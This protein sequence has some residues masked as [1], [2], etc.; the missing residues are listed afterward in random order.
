MKNFVVCLAL[1]LA[2]CSSPSG[3]NDSDH[4]GAGATASSGGSSSGGNTGA[5]ASGGT[6][7]GGTAGS[8]P[9]A[10]GS[11]AASGS[12]AAG[13][14]AP[15]PGFDGPVTT[16]RFDIDRSTLPPLYFKD[17]TLIV[18]ALDAT[19]A[20]VLSDGTVVDSTL[21]DGNVMF[22][23][24]GSSIEVQLENAARLDDA[25]TFSVPILKNDKAWAFSFG[26]DDN[27]NL[28][29]M[30][31]GA[32][33][34]GYFGTIFLI[35]ASIL[36]GDD[37]SWIETEGAVVARTNS[38]WSMGNH[39]WEHTG[40]NDDIEGSKESARK[41]NEKI[42]SLTATSNRPDYI[43]TAFAAPVFDNAWLDVILEMSAE[44]DTNL[45]FVESGGCCPSGAPMVLD[46]TATQWEEIQFSLTGLITRYTAFA[47]DYNVANAYIDERV[48]KV[49]PG[50]AIWLNN[51]S[52]GG[53]EGNVLP[54]LQYVKDVY[55]DSGADNV[56]VAPADEIY[57]YLL[58]RDKATVTYAGTD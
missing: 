34:I 50:H 27:V 21:A 58:I 37:E 15:D 28:K 16:L 6:T 24:P 41:T 31:D 29:A 1:S 17:I 51:L 49:E 13:G 56:W 18:D 26:F 40:V 20:Q 38:G 4:Q 46:G 22:S 10:G 42:E 52:H 7:T 30:L 45:L 44:Q 47:D 53:G 14:T 11:G 3:G 57:A 12:G 55:G 19:D 33:E 23:A 5:G 36:E 54:V 43:V 32:E 8:G 2:A 39:S 25:G 35:G 48:A 9:A